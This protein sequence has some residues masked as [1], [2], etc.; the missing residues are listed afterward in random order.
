MVRPRVLR[1]ITRLT[2]S[3]PSTHVV[4]AD[5]GLRERGWETLL[6]HGTVEAGEVE[7]DVTDYTIPMH[8]VAA[9]SRAI[10]PTADA[11]SL[12]SLARIIRRYRPDVIHSH[13]S[14]A[15]LLTRSAAMVASPSTAR[16]H[17]FHGTVFGG[18]FGSRST[19][20]IIRAERL[21]G[22]RTHR[23][24]AISELQRD[25]LIAQ[26]IAP[27]HRIAVVP[28]GI[29]LE[30][31]SGLDRTAARS[32]LGVPNDTIAVMSLG[33]LAPIKRVD[34]LIEAFATVTAAHPAAH[35]YIVGDGAIR[36]DLERQAATLGLD[37]R[38]TFV[39]RSADAPS[40]Y[41]AAD[42]VA[43][44]SDREGTPLS[45]IEAAAASRPVLATDVGGV[46]DVVADGI[47]GF[48]VAPH[49]RVGLGARLSSLLSDASVRA[50]LGAAAF[51]AAARFDATR[52]VDDLDGLYR[53]VLAE[54]HSRTEHRR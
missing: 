20:A 5:R 41:A 40:W 4:L 25:E 3:G 18:Y 17:T 21:L 35:L 39:G 2:V 47:T 7:F 22:W 28:L 31:Y 15:G 10:R 38:V 8:R 50:T 51:R 54:L 52:L 32:A 14:K 33:R 43:L 45:L 13:Q 46:R 23:V 48:L 1:V 11:S 34:R 27:P 26:R 30:R 24:I 6:V 16:I 37:D 42:L 49:D 12:A 36:P 29:D 44:T 19:Q 53:E 9:M